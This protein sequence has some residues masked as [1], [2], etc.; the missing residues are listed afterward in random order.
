MT[1]A[2]DPR[3]SC[4]PS[5]H[6]CVI[7]FWSSS[8]FCT[9]CS[10][11]ALY[12]FVLFSQWR[13]NLPSPPRRRAM[14]KKPRRRFALS[15]SHILISPRVL[16][17]CSFPWI[18]DTLP[19]FSFFFFCAILLTFEAKTQMTEKMRGRIREW[20]ARR[21]YSLAGTR[22]CNADRAVVSHFNLKDSFTSASL[23]LRRWQEGTENQKIRV[24][25]SR[26]LSMPPSMLLINIC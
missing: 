23:A 16:R 17:W 3:H 13:P 9:R 19:S 26:N 2:H 20:S 1:Y 18:I 22:L 5:V 24:L 12:V 8:P 10:A 6:S 25:Q 4:S 7:Q 11:L 14:I 21:V 15:D